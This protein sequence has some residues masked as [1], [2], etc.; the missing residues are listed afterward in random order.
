MNSV[1]LI[2]KP[3]AGKSLLFNK[4]TRMKQKVANFPGATVDIQAGQ[5]TPDIKVFDCPGVYSLQGLSEDE[6]ITL[7]FLMEALKTNTQIICILDPIRLESSL[8]LGLQIKKIAQE[9]SRSVIFAVNM[10]DLL[11]S[12][13]QKLRIDFLREKLDSVIVPMSAKTGEGLDVLRQTMERSFSENSNKEIALESDKVLTQIKNFKINPEALQKCGSYFSDEQFET[14]SIEAKNLNKESGLNL[15]YFFKTQNKLDDFLL[16]SWFGGL[17]FLFIMFVIF[18]SIF[19]WA[20]P[21]MGAVEWVVQ[22]VS[23]F[24]T[25]F[26][27]EGVFKDFLTEA[28]F[29]GVGSF[30]IFFPQ[31]FVLSFVI[32]LLEDSGYLSRAAYLCH[33]PLSLFGLS[34]NS[35]IPMLSGHACAIPAIMAAR[36]ISS[37]KV[38]WITMLTIPFMTCS[39]R[40]PVYSLLIASFIPPTSVFGG[41]IG[42]RG[43]ALFALYFF[44]LFMALLVSSVLSKV[45]F[46]KRH[47]HFPF[48][49]EFPPYRLPHWSPLLMKALRSVWAFVSKAGGIIFTITV[50]IW[51][52][53]YFPY[54]KLE[55]SW[56]AHIGRFLEPAMTPLGLDWKFGVATITAF[57]A[58]EVFV[59]TLGTLFGIENAGEDPV[60]LATRVVDSGLS[61]SSSL[62]LLAFYAIA[63]QCVATV[64]VLKKELNSLSISIWSLVAYGLLAYGVAFLIYRLSNFF[65]YST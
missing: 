7:S 11:K 61:V 20:E 53:G 30:I 32:G 4:M 34:G 38:K 58:R 25:S 31:I 19:T 65:F 51:I 5:W 59:G 21:A 1:L 57:L 24:V 43:F 33:K 15:K 60:G 37:K 18:Q 64:A 62:A 48:V 39:A 17:F 14:F 6:C 35:F 42:L 45:A 56:L 50:V 22:G 23:F 49:V 9:H 16:S 47:M 10:L 41:L 63:L 54:G 46:K 40:L 55:T 36:N 2:S 27:S 44:G 52:L 8:Y 26:V 13:R 12:Q 3:N 28:V 29:G